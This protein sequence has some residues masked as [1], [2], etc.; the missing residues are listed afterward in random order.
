MVC[1]FIISINAT[2]VDD[3]ELIVNIRHCQNTTLIGTQ[4]H[5]SFMPQ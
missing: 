4:K 2:G 3:L 5:L 1:C